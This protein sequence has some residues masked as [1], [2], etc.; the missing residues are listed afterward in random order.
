DFEIHIA[1]MLSLGS[2]KD[3]YDVLAE[4]KK[5]KNY[6]PVCFFGN[7]EDSAIRN[8][9]SESGIKTIELPGSHH[10]NNDFNKIAESILKE[11]N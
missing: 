8:R 5:M 2:S 1:D 10:Y 7:E 11:I 6:N 4:M 9:F 3:N